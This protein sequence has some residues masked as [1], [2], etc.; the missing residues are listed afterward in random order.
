M[1]R[2]RF[3]YEDGYKKVKDIKPTF[4]DILLTYC[5]PEEKRF[6]LGDTPDSVKFD[7]VLEDY[8]DK[9]LLVLTD[10]YDARVSVITINMGNIKISKGDIEDDVIGNKI[11]C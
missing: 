7:K 5:Y 11:K 10:Y 9:Q 4:E 8:G 1:K 6:S 2:V 3:T